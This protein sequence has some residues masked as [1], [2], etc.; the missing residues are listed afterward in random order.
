[1]QHARTAHLARSHRDRFGLAIKLLSVA[2]LV[3]IALAIVVTLTL[4]AKDQGTV[5]VELVKY[6]MQLTV[7][8]VVS[9][10]VAETFKG[11]E[12]GNQA[13]RE[14][15]LLRK[16]F[17]TQLGDA[18]RSVKETRRALRV[19]GLSR[20]YSASPDLLSD[21][22]RK[23]YGQQV[24]RIS[25]AHYQLEALQVQG[26]FV[27]A[28]DEWPAI[29]AKLKRME[30]YLSKLVSEHEE[31]GA[32]DP[33]RFADLPMLDDLTY[34]GGGRKFVSSLWSAH[35]DTV[36]LIYGQPSPPSQRPSWVQR[37]ERLRSAAMLPFRRIRWT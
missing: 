35:R 9:G 14:R 5:R 4:N 37:W 6:L 18:Y 2:A 21:A 29:R 23:V 17:A 1:M 20:A 24:R 10:I 22:Q 7:V 36:E 26:Q 33:L 8:L 15:T 13:A 30:R 32:R 31:K 27:F 3:P 16:E 25:A 19:V 11:I 28:P 34:K 12:R